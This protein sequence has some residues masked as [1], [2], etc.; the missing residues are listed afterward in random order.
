[1]YMADGIRTKKME[2]MKW[3]AIDKYQ[4]TLETVDVAQLHHGKFQPKEV[5]DDED[6]IFTSCG[7][8]FYP[9]NLTLPREEVY[10]GEDLFEGEIGYGMFDEVDYSVVPGKNAVI[11]GHGAFAVENVRTCCEY[12]AHQCYLV[13]RRKNIACPRVVSWMANR[14]LVALP[15]PEFLNLMKP[16]YD[17]LG[18]DVWSYYAVSA[19]EK[20]TTCMIQ[21]KAR[22]GIGDIYF[23]AQYMGKL[24]VVVEPKGIK[25]LSKGCVH[26]EGGRKLEDVTIILKLLG[27]VGEID[28]DRL[29]GIKEMY[30]FWVNDDP[31]RYLVAEPVSVMASNMGGTS[32]SP[33][34]LSW[35]KQGIW[36]FHYPE[37]YVYG[38]SAAGML[39]RH[40]AD[41]SDE[42]SMRPAYVVDA[43]HGTT[44]GM[45]VGMHTPQLS[46]AQNFDG[47]IKAVKHRL[48]HPIDKFLTAAQED[49][50]YYAKKFL[51]EGFGV[52]KPYPTYPFTPKSARKD[53]INHM[54]MTGEHVL[55]C[56]FEDFKMTA[57]EIH[58][59][60]A[61]NN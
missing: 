48:C 10:K 41:M 18:W 60:I 16:M 4:L 24:E 2:P 44:T 17:F 31:R 29:F 34:A 52:D 7:T 57:E 28:N 53:I 21:Q 3:W 37:Q 43:R 55:P 20:R 8:I 47:Y 50:D 38:V 11:V 15:C 45:A 14:S 42:H 12:G 40:A 59:A 32:L 25:R 23:L 30:G 22:F 26:L 36:F 49:W 61:Q 58:H 46:E 6:R 9:G 27:F 33:G 35:A 1:M 54:R 51:A 39:P 5:K 19:N 56:D 13:C